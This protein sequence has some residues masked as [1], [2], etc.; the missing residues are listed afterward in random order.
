MS[1]TLVDIFMTTRIRVSLSNVKCYSKLKFYK[2]FK[3][4]KSF[5]AITNRNAAIRF[6]RTL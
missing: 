4:L 6:E 2:T 5:F 1:L 3:Y